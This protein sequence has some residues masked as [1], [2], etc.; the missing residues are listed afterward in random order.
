[1][2]YGT[3]VLGA[4][5]LAATVAGTGW[6]GERD[7][8]DRPGRRVDRRI[9][10]HGPA[11]G[12]A[13]SD[14]GYIGVSVDELNA[15]EMR[16][17]KLED[18]GGARVAKVLRSGPAEKGGLKDGDV[19]VRFHGEPVVSARQLVR[20]V[21]EIP[22]GRTIKI[23]VRRDGAPLSLSVTVGEAPSIEERLSEHLVMD[24][25]PRLKELSRGGARWHELAPPL[26]GLLDEGARRHR[27]G[28]RCQDISGQ[29]AQYFHLDRSSGVLIAEVEADS[30]AA[31]A[32][33]KAGDVVLSIGGHTVEDASELRRRVAEADEGATLAV[34][35][36]RDGK[37]LEL[38]V[39]LG[40]GE[41]HSHSKA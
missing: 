35:V 37:T 14:G 31:K 15:E 17:L 7:D 4:L 5:A 26:D 23:D 28:V 16:A 13:F 22:P 18:Q 29:L 40:D 30:P 25:L 6:A 10:I 21:N 3:T 33:L 36:L 41:S 19:I 9:E 32:G 2:G 39:K 24:Q 38:E 20:M 1:M 27:L 12:L 34:K 11:Q 8:D